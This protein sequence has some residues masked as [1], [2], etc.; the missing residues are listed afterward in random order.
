MIEKTKRS[1]QW[2]EENKI[3][4]FPKKRK[5]AGI[6]FTGDFWDGKVIEKEDK[7]RQL[8]ISAAKAAQ[9]TVLEVVTHKFLPQ[10]MTG[11]VLLGESHIAIHTWPE[12]NYTAID[13]FT[14]GDKTK[15]SLAMEYLK[16]ELCPERVEIN[17]LKRGGSEF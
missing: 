5:Y 6:H 15:P 8:L 1:I 9:S 13:I 12:I 7:M 14:C 16:A 17:K 2:I 10:G 3:S 11:I 4:F